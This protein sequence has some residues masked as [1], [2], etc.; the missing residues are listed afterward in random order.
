MFCHN[1]EAITTLVAQPWQAALLPEFGSKRFSLAQLCE[2]RWIR[3]AA[4]SPMP[5]FELSALEVAEVP[6]AFTQQS[7]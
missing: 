3:F 4:V 7:P 1:H 2:L 6:P 5:R